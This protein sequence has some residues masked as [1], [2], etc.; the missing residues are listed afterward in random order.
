TAPP[1]T[2]SP[3]HG[4][5]D[6]DTVEP[7]VRLVWSGGESLKKLEL[8]L[9]ED[10]EYKSLILDTSL[11][12]SA[13]TLL[14]PSLPRG[15]VFHW[16]LRPYGPGGQ[17]EWKDMWFFTQDSA[18]KGRTLMAI[19]DD[20]AP[21]LLGDSSEVGASVHIEGGTSEGMVVRMDA[22]ASIGFGGIA[23][24]TQAIT[25][26]LADSAREQTSLTIDLPKIS[27]PGPD[28]DPANSR[29][30]VQNSS[31][32]W[33]LLWDVAP[34]DT[35]RI[36]LP[37]IPVGNFFV[38]VD[39]LP[40]VI[41]DRTPP[42]PRAAGTQ[43][44]IVGSVTDEIQN[45]RVMMYYRKGG[46]SVIDSTQVVADSGGRFDLPLQSVTLDNNGF[47]YWLTGN[48]GVNRTIL[49]RTDI[50]ISVA[51]VISPDTIRN[52]E[53]RLFSL[54]SALARDSVRTVLGDL[55]TYGRHDDWLLFYRGP[56][57]LVEYGP[58]LASLLPGRAYWLKTWTRQIRTEVRSGSTIPVNKPFEIAIAPRS[59]M[60][61]ANPYLF[62]V[63]W[64]SVLDSSG[65]AADELMGPYSYHDSAWIA[66]APAATLDPFDGYYVYNAT[67]D[68]VRM[69][70]PSVA[71][72]RASLAKR[73]V[74]GT[75]KTT[76]TWQVTGPTGR[77]HGLRFGL[78]EGASSEK[79]DTGLDWMKPENLERGVVRAWFTR[80]GFGGAPY[81]TDFVSVADSLGASWTITV[82][83]LEAGKAYTCAI[84]GMEGLPGWAR[85]AVLDKRTG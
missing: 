28:P 43:A 16:R 73:S 4:P 82:A 45:I 49:P 17:G 51:P 64:Q 70:I 15:T 32:G 78:A 12:G 35:G 69:R 44:T 48:D 74:A 8:Q 55:G 33:E 27:G 77:D 66:P 34:D 79:A 62:K 68:T 72:P 2:L 39:T 7:V 80:E 31:G 6:G 14:T 61:V 65:L 29:V 47:E 5:V 13:R 23:P 19:V 22:T 63:A 75:R 1:P 46:S 42:E 59:W 67:S 50:P 53:W 60:G 76:L 40:P 38:G 84:G 21:L 81:Q 85:V 57:G 52:L 18:S 24:V 54:P 36:R 3:I 71:A 26:H 30:Y 11:P 56:E 25:M 41:D 9:S 10:M 37:L 83:N 58:D 20:D